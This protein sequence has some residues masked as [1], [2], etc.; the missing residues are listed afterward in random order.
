M[1]RRPSPLRNGG[2]LQK[3]SL[4][5]SA[6]LLENVAKVGLAQETEERRAS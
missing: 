1:G 5:F 3:E 6:A 2:T 4:F